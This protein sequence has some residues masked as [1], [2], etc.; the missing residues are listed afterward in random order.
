MQ[1]RQARDSIKETADFL[2]PT[3]ASIENAWV[4][5]VRSCTE[6]LTFPVMLKNSSRGP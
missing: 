2:V 3:S 4:D 1:T 6:A 5:T